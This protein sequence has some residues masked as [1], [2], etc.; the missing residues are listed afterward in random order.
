MFVY[1]SLICTLTYLS[2]L[3]LRFSIVSLD[4]HSDDD[5]QSKRLLIKN[6]STC[7]DGVYCNL[8]VCTESPYTPKTSSFWGRTYVFMSQTYQWIKEDSNYYQY[9]I[10]CFTEFV[11]KSYYSSKSMTT[12]NLRIQNYCSSWTLSPRKIWSNIDSTLNLRLSIGFVYEF[13]LEIQEFNIL[14][15]HEVF[16]SE[17]HFQNFRH[18]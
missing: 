1:Q 8:Y 12:R 7:V 18:P 9:S 2:N 17:L 11:F 4:I 6:S 5:H 14:Q 13:H 16:C 10:R 15:V 3:R